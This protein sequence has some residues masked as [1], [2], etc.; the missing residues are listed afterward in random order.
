MIVFNWLFS[1]LREWIERRATRRNNEAAIRLA[2]DQ[3]AYA[4][5]CDDTA[6]ADFW[7]DVEVGISQRSK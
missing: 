4:E 3:A 2:R 7:R 6:S 5:A 1:G